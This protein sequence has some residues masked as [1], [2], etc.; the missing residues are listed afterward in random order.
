MYE[1]VRQELTAF[2]LPPKRIRNEVY[3]EA[4]DVSK[5][6]GFPRS[7]A[8]KSFELTVRIGGLTTVIPARAT[9]TLLVA[10][11]R[12]GLAPPSE[13]RSGTCG[14]CHALLVAGDVYVNPDGDGRRAADM[15]YGYIHPCSSYPLSDLELSVPRGNLVGSAS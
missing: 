11:E 2:G 10:M 3:G 5:A 13:C 7:A 4:R 14:V 12:A 15:Q 6:P 9:E 8:N 1:F